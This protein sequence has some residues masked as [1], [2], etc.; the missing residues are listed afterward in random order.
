[1]KKRKEEAI[2]EANAA[3]QEYESSLKKLE[4]T[5]GEENLKEG[6]AS[7]RR[8]FGP[9]KREVLVP[10]K[11][12]ETDNYYGNS[13]SEGDLEAEANMDAGNGTN[14]DVQKNVKTD[15]FILHV[16]HE[17]HPDSVFKVMDFLFPAFSGVFTS[18]VFFFFLTQVM[19]FEI[20]RALKMLLGTQVRRHHM[21]LLF[22]HQA[23]GKRFNFPSYYSFFYIGDRAF[24]ANCY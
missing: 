13:D 19:C 6:A 23:H 7:G 2:Q 3:L 4:G 11:K 18:N 10:S 20:H 1:M 21:M 14:N 9:V 5:G 12:I 8:V 17:S 22:L 15:S 24:N 16:D